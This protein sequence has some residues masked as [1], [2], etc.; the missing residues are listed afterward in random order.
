MANHNCST[1]RL[2]LSSHHVRGL[3]VERV[4]LDVVPEPEPNQNHLE[5]LH[6]LLDDLA[7]EDDH[8]DVAPVVFLGVV[9]LLL[10]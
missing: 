10:D 2:F 7:H 4:S 3:Q 6:L 5:L 1:S 9:L 8:A